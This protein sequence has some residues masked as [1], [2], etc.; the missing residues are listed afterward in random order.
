MSSKMVKSE[1]IEN[2]SRV[3][4]QEVQTLIRDSSEIT[5]SVVLAGKSYDQRQLSN[6]Y[7]GAL[8]MLEVKVS[9]LT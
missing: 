8:T 3:P 1:E 5:N 6:G 2:A 7:R 4:M 9:H